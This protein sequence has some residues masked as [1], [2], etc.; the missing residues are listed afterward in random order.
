MQ[1]LR[2]EFTD[3]SAAR[4]CQILKSLWFAPVL[5][6]S[7][8]PGLPRDQ[9][10]ADT[11]DDLGGKVIKTEK[12]K[13]NE[14]MHLGDHAE[15]REHSKKLRTDSEAAASTGTDNEANNVAISEPAA[16]HDHGDLA[17]AAP[18]IKP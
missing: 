10:G 14:S 8:D 5:A 18:D 2:R 4:R 1:T 13:D 15:L 9:D 12:H 11:A 6:P 3:L 7:V 17:A 16:L